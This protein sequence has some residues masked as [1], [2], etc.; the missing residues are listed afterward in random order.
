M[1]ESR[2]YYVRDINQEVCSEQKIRFTE[3]FFPSSYP[4]HHLQKVVT[5]VE[6]EKWYE[7]CKRLYFMLNKEERGA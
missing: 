3:T 7:T 5:F 2:E 4:H 1:K 6:R